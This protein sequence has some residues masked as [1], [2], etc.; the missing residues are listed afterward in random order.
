MDKMSNS[1]FQEVSSFQN[2]HKNEDLLFG[3]WKD[4]DE[5]VEDVVRI[6]RQ[7]RT[8]QFSMEKR[9]P[10]DLCLPSDELNI[11]VENLKNNKNTQIYKSADK[12]SEDLGI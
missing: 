9:I 4:K 1:K 11:R 5:P 7:D 12:L 2:I 3:L 6:I 8:K 10:F